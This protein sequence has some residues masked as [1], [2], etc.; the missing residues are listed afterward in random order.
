MDKTSS[1]NINQGGNPF[2]RNLNAS[3]GEP[4]QSSGGVNPHKMQETPEYKDLVRLI[5]KE[6]RFEIG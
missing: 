5:M 2:F 3:Y 6:I 4:W 1:S